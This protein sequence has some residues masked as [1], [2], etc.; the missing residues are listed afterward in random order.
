M[1]RTKFITITFLF[2]FA[3][4]VYAKQTATLSDIRAFLSGEPTREQVS[5]YVKELEEII[6]H[7]PDDCR[8]YEMLALCYDYLG[9]HEKAAEMMRQEIKH[10][11]EG[12]EGFDSLYGNLAGQCLHLKRYEDAKQALDKALEINPNNTMNHRHL[13]DYYIL[14]GKYKEAAVQ[15]KTISG[16][17]SKED[18]YYDAYFFAL[19]LGIKLEDLIFL[20]RQAVNANPNSHL[21]HR[22]LATALRGISFEDIDKKFPLVMEELNKAWELNPKFIPTYISIA[23][24]YMFMGMKTGEKSILKMP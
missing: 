18:Y 2:L 6:K 10:F 23:D 15:L 9:Q 11:P 14:T 16:L 24:M 20:F 5:G 17:D 19:K 8:N 21:A 3:V 7:D 1:R 13:F 4:L 12:E 22:A